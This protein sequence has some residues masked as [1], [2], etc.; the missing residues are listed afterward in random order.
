[1]GGRTLSRE[2]AEGWQSE[3]EVATT[4]LLTELPAAANER[5]EPCDR[6]AKEGIDDQEV[7]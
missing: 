3:T 6:S 1:M 7:A 4:R 2:L 5:Q